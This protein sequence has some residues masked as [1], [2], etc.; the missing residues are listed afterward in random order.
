MARDLGGDLKCNKSRLNSVKK[1][2]EIHSQERC[3][4]EQITGKNSGVYVP[5]KVSP[6]LHGI[7]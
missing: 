1:D 7:I 2:K 5:L 6:E 4:H 3:C